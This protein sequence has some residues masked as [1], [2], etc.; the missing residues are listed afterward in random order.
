MAMRYFDVIATQEDLL[1]KIP[2]ID[3]NWIAKLSFRWRIFKSQLI[4]QSVQSAT[5]FMLINSAIEIATNLLSNGLREAGGS[6]TIDGKDLQDLVSICFKCSKVGQEDKV[7]WLNLANDSIEAAQLWCPK[8]G[9]SKMQL[10]ILMSLAEVYISQNQKIEAQ[11][12]VHIIEL[13]HENAPAIPLLKC[14]ILSMS[15]ESTSAE[16]TDVFS[17]MIEYNSLVPHENKVKL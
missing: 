2:C 8:F 7:T 3:S 14:Q 9:F 4:W 16:Y 17:K 6:K 15:T 1:R 11:E 5:A 10:D 13:N 12:T